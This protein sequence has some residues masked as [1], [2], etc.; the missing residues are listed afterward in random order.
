[1]PGDVVRQ[2]LADLAADLVDARRIDHDELGPFEPGPAEG[3]LLPALGGAGDGRAVGRADLEDLLADQGVQDRRLA[4]A[5][6]AE[7]GDLDRGLVELLGEVAELAQLVGQRGLFLG[8][9]LEARPGSPRGSPRALDG[10]VRFSLRSVGPVRRAIRSAPRRRPWYRSFHCR[11]G[12]DGVSR[13]TR[14]LAEVDGPRQI[15]PDELERDRHPVGRNA[16][17]ERDSGQAGVSSRGN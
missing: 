6:H 7:R 10:L 15:Q 2:R 12:S 5:D 9:E 1:M 14:P 3:A 4:P 11:A 13:T 16:D 17:R 8:R